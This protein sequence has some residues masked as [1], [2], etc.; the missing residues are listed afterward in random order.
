MNQSTL[1][2]AFFD[3]EGSGIRISAQQGSR[4][5][6]EI[7]GDFNPIHDPGNKRFC[8]PGDLLFSLVLSEHGLS[9]R[10]SFSFE[11]MV[12]EGTGLSMI[13]VG[14]DRVSLRDQEGKAYLEVTRAGDATHDQALIEKLIR[15]YV[16]FSGQN[17]P[18]ILVP[19]MEKHRVM[20]NT[21]RPLIIYESMS[22]DLERLDVPDLTLR[23]VDSTLEVN[24]RRGDARLYFELR[25][26]DDT[27]GTGFKKLV[28]SGLRG[29]EA[30]ALQGLVDRYA[31]WK[32]AFL[33]SNRENAPQRRPSS[34]ATS[35]PGSR[36]GA[37]GVVTK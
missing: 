27:I 35:A 22:F 1:L 11:G 16:A 8:V 15:H 20:I 36:S 10:M 13:P 37:R 9:Q 23:L 14:A 18:H 17:F 26:G 6:K 5:A 29:Y 34:A 24:G 21:D 33:G 12:G 19:L 3:D 32:A 25:S 2:A 31:G 28:L 4:F 30:E 7:A